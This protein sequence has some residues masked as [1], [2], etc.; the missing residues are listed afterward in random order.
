MIPEEMERLM[1]FILEQ[2]AQF[3]V[4]MDKARERMAES[5]ERAAARRLLFSPGVART[6]TETIRP[7]AAG[8]SSA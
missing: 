7:S 2:Q 8:A 6:D 1:Q 4:D 5:D 3:S